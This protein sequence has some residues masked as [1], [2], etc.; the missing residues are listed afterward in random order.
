MRRA[1]IAVALPLLL[2]G[3]GGGAGAHV[4]SLSAKDREFCKQQA[5]DL[6][7]ARTALLGGDAARVLDGT[8]AGVHALVGYDVDDQDLAMLAAKA[9]DRL[10]AANMAAQKVPLPGRVSEAD[11]K[12]AVDALAELRDWCDSS[13][14]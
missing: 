8:D 3:C 10:G 7:Q 6:E 4:E 12:P 5:V 11:T 9:M 13:G 14:A 1:L 2:A